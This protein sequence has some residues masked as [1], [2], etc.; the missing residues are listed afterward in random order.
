[1][2][3]GWYLQVAIE[4]L[5]QELIA[6]KREVEG[7]RERAQKVRLFIVMPAQAS[8]TEQEHCHGPHFHPSYHDHIIALSKQRQ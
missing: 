8:Y 6:S 5:Q 1:M 7:L 4:Q 3:N 2:V